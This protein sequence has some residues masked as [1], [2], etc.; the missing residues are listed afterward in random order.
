MTIIVITIR[1]P[2]VIINK[3]A[4]PNRKHTRVN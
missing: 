4:E 2:S 3:T 1:S